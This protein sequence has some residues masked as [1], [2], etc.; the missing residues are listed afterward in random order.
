MPLT[1]PQRKAL[2]AALSL[3]ASAT[4]EQ[5][6][7]EVT[8]RGLDAALSADL[9]LLAIEAD[10]VTRAAAAAEAERAAADQA[11]AAAE[12]AAGVSDDP[13]AEITDPSDDARD[14]QGFTRAIRR[15]IREGASEAFAYYESIGDP[16][17]SLFATSDGQLFPV[18]S[19]DR[20]L[21]FARTLPEGQRELK[22]ITRHFQVD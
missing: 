4:E 2:A 7:A 6:L 12:A 5:V 13:D 3:P 19:Y 10:N 8:A 1:T 16:Q 21:D 18:A 20:A 17:T 15:Q 22:Q 9:L 14:S 11:A